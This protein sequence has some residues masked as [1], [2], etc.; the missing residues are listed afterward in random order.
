MDKKIGGLIWEPSY[1][2]EVVLLFGMLLGRLNEA[3]LIDECSGNFPDCLLKTAD[4]QHE[5]RAEFELFSSYFK[6]HGHNPDKCDLIVCWEHNWPESPLQVLELSSLINDKDQEIE[7]LG[8][9]HKFSIS[10]R[11]L[12]LIM[13]PNERKYKKTVWDEIS[14]FQRVPPEKLQFIQ[15]L[16]HFCKE[17][18]LGVEYGQGDKV[19]SFKVHFCAPKAPTQA[20]FGIDQNCVVWLNFKEEDL[21][22]EIA[23]EFR[24]RLGRLIPRLKNHLQRKTWP[25]FKIE[26]EKELLAFEDTIS[27]LAKIDWEKTANS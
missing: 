7:I 3:Y 21:T 25:Q 23:N 26:N 9:T 16:R 2:E 20:V 18:G 19:A 11:P 17:Q 12:S 8:V 27:W 10:N 24:E 13:K 4:G 14:F 6:D 22:K 1:E 15:R 5:I